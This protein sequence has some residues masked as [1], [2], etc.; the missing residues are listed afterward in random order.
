MI[1]QQI[2]DAPRMVDPRPTTIPPRVS[3]PLILRCFF[4][5]VSNVERRTV[6][7]LFWLGRQSARPM[8]GP[9]VA[10]GSRFSRRETSVSC[11]VRF[12]FSSGGGVRGQS[13][14][15]A[16][17]GGRPAT[18]TRD[19]AETADYTS[20]Q[21]VSTHYKYTHNRSTERAAHSSPPSA[22]SR[23]KEKERL[24]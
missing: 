21:T 22:L 14:N 1:P 20:Q 15:R 12:F 19:R 10:S 6:F 5:S 11:F 7:G 18:R 2:S 17:I 24:S 9:A 8:A 13:K 23:P 16:V 3:P 4:R